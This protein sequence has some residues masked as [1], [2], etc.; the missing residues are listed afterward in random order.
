MVGTAEKSINLCPSI[1]GI[2]IANFDSMDPKT[3]QRID[4]LCSRFKLQIIDALT[5]DRDIPDFIKELLTLDPNAVEITLGF[6]SYEAIPNANSLKDRIKAVANKLYD[7]HK[8][9]NAKSADEIQALIESILRR[10]LIDLMHVK[11]LKLD[12]KYNLSF[13]DI[14]NAFLQ[15]T[16]HIINQ[17]EKA[18]WKDN[19]QDAIRNVQDKHDPYEVKNNKCII[20]ELA[21]KD[22][23]HQNIYPP[24][25]NLINAYIQF[26][27]LLGI[28]G[29][30]DIMDDWNIYIK[31]AFTVYEGLQKDIQELQRWIITNHLET[32]EERKQLYNF[33]PQSIPEEFRR[34]NLYQFIWAAIKGERVQINGETSK[35]SSNDQYIAQS[36]TYLAYLFHLLKRDDGF[37]L[38]QLDET[39]DNI[40][41]ILDEKFWN[42]LSTLKNGDDYLFIY[43]TSVNGMLTNTDKTEDCP[44]QHTERARKF[45]DTLI[46]VWRDEAKPK[47][48]ISTLL[49]IL[50][51]SDA[52]ADQQRAQATVSLSKNDLDLNNPKANANHTLLENLC[53]KYAETL[54]LT[55]DKS[56]LHYTKIPIG[57][58]KVVNKAKWNSKEDLPKKAF[59]AV[60]V[61]MAIPVDIYGNIIENYNPS[62]HPHAKTIRR[63][64]RFIPY[65]IAHIE[66]HAS[67]SCLKHDIYKTVQAAE[68][69]MKI[70]AGP[71]PDDRLRKLSICLAIF[72]EKYMKEVQSIF[73]S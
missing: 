49:K 9:E 64:F 35:I 8:I 29:N 21:I 54:G 32:D 59:L 43:Y 39:N 28:E 26:L 33:T 20:E 10:R 67:A 6:I 63:E 3:R 57:S 15:S 47:S 11:H 56:D 36:I 34:M 22:L 42:A 55:E 4:N 7:G 14:I 40:E 16:N 58:F 27:K 2:G 62:E 65:D 68:L 48:D 37:Y 1:N 45:N 38:S 25:P 53:R 23:N 66:K 44:I 46:K 41:R 18:S 60:K 72:Y 69:L 30:Y 61:Y 52:I 71:H 13:S 5:S 51:G 73:R 12:N 50:S 17:K 70:T 31:S 19:L 24:N